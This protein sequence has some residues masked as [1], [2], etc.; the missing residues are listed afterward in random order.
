M[1]QFLAIIGAIVVAVLALLV[2]ALVLMFWRLRKGLREFSANLP[3][4]ASIAT[5]ARI[6]LQKRE[7]MNWRDEAAANALINGLW[8]LG[9]QDAG[10]YE[11][12]EIPGLLVRGLARPEE[13]LW[14]VVYEHPLAGVMFDIVTRYTQDG[15]WIG[16]L[17]TSTAK[18]GGELDRRPGYDKIYEPD[19]DARQL[20]E[21]HLRERRPDVEF[22]PIVPVAFATEF[23]S[24]YANEMDWRLSRGM[25]TEDEIRA[26]AAKQ[27]EE[28]SAEKLTMLRQVHEAQASAGLVEVIREKFLKETPLSAAEWESLRERIVIVH[29]RMLPKSVF[30]EFKAWSF[31]EPSPFDDDDKPP[32]PNELTPLQGFAHL[33]STLS[34][35]RRFEKI[36]DFSEPVAAHVYKA[37]DI[38]VAA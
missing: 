8:P 3:D 21:L 17:T 22:W 9:F 19:F 4:L 12:S 25:A 14:A 37:A 24:A 18:Q 29:E 34:A 15:A 20:Y 35:A 11:V 26:V 6:R 23:E 33:N 1:L 36:A 27:G 10:S 16:S 5:P 32:Y 13:N 30:A 31:D 38:A 2:L 7:T 28:L